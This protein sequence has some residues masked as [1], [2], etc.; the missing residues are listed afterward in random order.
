MN[1]GTNW[2][3]MT[4]ETDAVIIGAQELIDRL[5]DQIAPFNPTSHFGQQVHLQYTTISP[6]MHQRLGVDDPYPDEFEAA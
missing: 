2:Q 5:M 3:D 6:V 4:N 1:Y